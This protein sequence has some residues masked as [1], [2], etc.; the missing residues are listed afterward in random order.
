M[1]LGPSIGEHFIEWKPANGEDRALGLVDF[2]IFPHL[3]HPDIPEN[4]MADAER[5]ASGMNG[6][7]YAID[8]QT[9]IRV[10]DGEV[11]VVSEGS[12]RL[13]EPETEPE[14]EPSLG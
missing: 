6:P 10:V 2:S 8:D 7:G 5:W 14:P 4:S 3:D 1:A 11:D 13:F 9:A 12:W